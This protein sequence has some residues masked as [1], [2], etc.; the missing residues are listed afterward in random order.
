MHSDELWYLA[1]VLIPFCGWAIDSRA[2]DNV[3][4]KPFI[5]WGCLIASLALVTFKIFVLRAKT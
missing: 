3:R 4:K 5:F 2:R 1:A